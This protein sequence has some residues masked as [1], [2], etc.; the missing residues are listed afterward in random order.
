[1]SI[2]QLFTIQPTNEI[3][4]KI[5]YCFGLTGLDDDNEFSQLDMASQNTLKKFENIKDEIA[6][7]YLPCK[8]DIYMKDLNFKS[9]ITISRQFLKTINYTIDSR[10]KFIKSK[11]YLMYKIITQNEKISRTKNKIVVSFN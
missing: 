10:E 3:I 8:K 5:I 2:K 7:Y 4:E 6:S 11:K 1:M 9:V